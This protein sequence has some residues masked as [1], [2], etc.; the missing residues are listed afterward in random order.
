MS[1]FR[2]RACS[3][4]AL[5]VS[6]L[7]FVLIAEADEKKRGILKIEKP[8]HDFGS[9]TQGTVV[10]H[11][12]ILKNVGNADLRIQQ[13]VAACGCTATA[14]T[15][16]VIPAGGEGTIH[17][18]FDTAGFSGSASKG[19][20]VLTT[21][22]DHPSSDLTIKGNIETD[23][24]VQPAILNFGDVPRSSNSSKTVDVTVRQGSD[25][26]LSDVK[27]FSKFIEAKKVS[28]DPKNM[29]I[30]VTL[31]P[32]APLGVLRDRIVVAYGKDSSSLL[33]VPVVANIKGNLKVEPATLSFGIIEGPNAMKRSI[34]IENQG[35]EQLEIQSVEPSDSA[36]KVSHE[37]IKP[38]K[39]FVVHV[40]IDPAAV[41]QD[42]R[43]SVNIKTNSAE[44]SQLVVNVYGILP[45]K[46]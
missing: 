36:M 38:G 16:E 28:S 15:S 43:G 18:Q 19:V 4:V 6:F 1:G 11:D 33:N 14:T 25:V 27:N 20:R 22:L 39:I 24:K 2:I 46:T 23:V 37:V 10:K 44:E 8:V 30:A 9:V 13:V 34:K 7:C 31:K 40:S 17:V 45:P 5:I 3:C 26:Q 32:G 35:T 41:K 29:R 12:F 42:L 21:D